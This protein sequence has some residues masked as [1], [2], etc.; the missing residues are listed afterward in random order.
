MGHFISVTSLVY[1]FIGIELKNLVIT[2]TIFVE[3]INE[4]SVK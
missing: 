4:K 1:R 2:T 3:N